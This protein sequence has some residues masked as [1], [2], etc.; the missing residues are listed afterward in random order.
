MAP[1]LIAPTTVRLPTTNAQSVEESTMTAGELR[2]ILGRAKE[3]QG[4]LRIK[5]ARTGHGTDPAVIT[6]V[7]DLSAFIK[8]AERLTI[9][10][11]DGQIVHESYMADL[12]PLAD[13][14]DI[15]L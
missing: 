5:A 14:C 10:L 8:E 2:K 11:G 15:A 12:R 7:Q 3:R 4:R 6:E 13:E 9:N 1:A